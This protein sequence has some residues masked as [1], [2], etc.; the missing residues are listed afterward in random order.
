M[1]KRSFALL[2]LVLAVVVVLALAGTALAYGSGKAVPTVTSFTGTDNLNGTYTLVVTWDTNGAK[3]IYVG[4][5]TTKYVNGYYWKLDHTALAKGTWT[6]TMSDSTYGTPSK[7]VVSNRAGVG[8][9]L[10]I[11][12]Q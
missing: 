8:A 5:I 4:L 6:F 12:W 9:A 11:T 1:N 3:P 2:V 7:A 10:T